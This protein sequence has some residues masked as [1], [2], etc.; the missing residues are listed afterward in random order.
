M[1]FD[2]PEVV[3]EYILELEYRLTLAMRMDCPCAEYLIRRKEFIFKYISKQAKEQSL[4]AEE[5]FAAYAKRVHD[6][7]VQNG[8]ESLEI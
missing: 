6:R 2:E 8:P 5:V 4:D 3:D 7:H 1:N